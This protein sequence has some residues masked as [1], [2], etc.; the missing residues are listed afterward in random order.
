MAHL[1][2][3]G[4]GGHRDGHPSDHIGNSALANGAAEPGREPQNNMGEGSIQGGE[5]EEGRGR[6]GRHAV[7]LTHAKEKIQG[8]I[9]LYSRRILCCISVARHCSSAVPSPPS[10]D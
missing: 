6:V 5:F 9:A 10:D 7:D 3:A 1:E 8:L 4:G 2:P